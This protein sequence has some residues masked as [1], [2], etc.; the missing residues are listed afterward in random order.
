MITGEPW[1][2]CTVGI[3]EGGETLGRGL[4]WRAR[5]LAGGEARP[6]GDELRWTAK[7]HGECARHAYVEESPE[8]N[9]MAVYGR[10][11]CDVG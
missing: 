8:T 7:G 3:D 5:M 10:D 2:R 11:D 1:R 6:S 9:K 4:R